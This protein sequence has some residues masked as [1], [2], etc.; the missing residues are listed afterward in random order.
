MPQKLSCSTRDDMTFQLFE[1]IVEDD[2]LQLCKVYSAPGVISLPVLAI[3]AER[4]MIHMGDFHVS[5]LPLVTLLPFPTVVAC[6]C[7]ITSVATASLAGTP[8]KPHAPVGAPS[9][10]FLTT[11]RVSSRVNCH[12]IPSLFFHHAAL[13]TALFTSPCGTPFPPHPLLHSPL[14]PGMSRTSF[15]SCPLLICLP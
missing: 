9:I 3:F 4:G 7:K 10:T 8:G 5:I 14:L 1:V 15:V 11:G 13:T 6:L 12:S 2:T